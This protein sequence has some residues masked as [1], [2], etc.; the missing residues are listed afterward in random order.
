MYIV[1]L[2]SLR[3]DGHCLRLRLYWYNGNT[4]LTYI[5]YRHLLLASNGTV[6]VSLRCGGGSHSTEYP[7]V[8]TTMQKVNSQLSLLPYTGRETST[9]Q[10]AAMLCFWGVKAGW[11]IP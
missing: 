7:L 6:S 10:S 11:V 4:V 2:L 5:T 9:G 1:N 8:A 3:L